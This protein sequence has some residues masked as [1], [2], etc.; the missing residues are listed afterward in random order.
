VKILVPYFIINSCILF[1]FFIAHFY[2]LPKPECFFLTSRF[3]ILPSHLVLPFSFSSSVCVCTFLVP[4]CTRRWCSPIFSKN[5][6]YHGSHSMVL[7]THFFF[8]SFFLSFSSFV[9]F[10]YILV[11][12]FASKLNLLSVLGVRGQLATWNKRKI[13]NCIRFLSNKTK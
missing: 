2:T 4:I 1:N 7:L 9:R 13:C 10:I 6:N 5:T 8:L 11:S 3:N 12:L